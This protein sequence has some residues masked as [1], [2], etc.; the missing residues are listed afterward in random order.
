MNKFFFGRILTIT[1]FI[2]I[3]TLFPANGQEQELTG[4][5]N[6]IKFEAPYSKIKLDF[7]E[8][9]NKGFSELNIDSL[10]VFYTKKG[11]KVGPEII[12][13]GAEVEVKL[14]RKGY[15]TS[16]NSITFIASTFEK[17]EE[18]KNN[19]EKKT[20]AT[21]TYTGRS[22]FAVGRGLGSNLGRDISFN[23]SKP[24]WGVYIDRVGKIKIFGQDLTANKYAFFTLGAY[25]GWRTYERSQWAN[26]FMQNNQPATIATKESWRYF[27]IGGR[28][29]FH[30]LAFRPWKRW[31][32][33]AGFMLSYNF[34]SYS[35]NQESSGLIGL[36]TAN[37]N[38]PNYDYYNPA[39]SNGKL[40]FFVGSRFYLLR[41]LAAFAELGYGISF[42]QFGLSLNGR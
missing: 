5:A 37:G 28:T 7:R 22:T 33:Y 26:G 23:S 42:F 9:E 11:K 21:E 6:V 38:N 19:N 13:E 39:K 18:I 12:N 2:Y 15:K 17:K 41:R 29:T 4:R 27:I 10:T 40:S 31:D 3:L 32:P 24:S 1:F 20:Y 8:E 34:L 36:K 16:V 30:L 14:R 35:N 25:V